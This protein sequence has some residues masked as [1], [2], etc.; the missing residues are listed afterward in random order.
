MAE[1]RVTKELVTRQTDQVEIM[2]YA[3]ATSSL[4]RQS[5]AAMTS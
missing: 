2:K 3:V 1:G 5:A 4:N